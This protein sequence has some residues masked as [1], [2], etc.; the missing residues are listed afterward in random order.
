[1][2][3]PEQGPLAGNFY[4]V[5]GGNRGI[6]AATALKIAENGGLVGVTATTKL[7]VDNANL[8]LEPFG[9]FG[10]QFEYGRDLSDSAYAD[11]VAEM[12]VIASRRFKGTT[13]VAGKVGVKGLVNNAGRTDNANFVSL[14]AD[15]WRDIFEVNAISPALW[16]KAAARYMRGMDASVV[17]VG[18]SARWGHKGQASYSAS[19]ASLEGISATLAIDLE[20]WGG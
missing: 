13:H 10:H 11:A 8:A 18:S 3:A 16:T 9:G 20:K 12:I 14:T 19:K 5:T 4:I 15:G 1:M 7:G 6:G 2:P 17:W